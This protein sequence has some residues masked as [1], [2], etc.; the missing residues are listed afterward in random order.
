MARWTLPMSWDKMPATPCRSKLLPGT[1]RSEE[2]T[3]YGCSRLRCR[4]KLISSES[5]TGPNFSR[6]LSRAAS[7]GAD[8]RVWHRILQVFQHQQ[9]YP[10]TRGEDSGTHLGLAGGR[11]PTGAEGDCAHPAGQ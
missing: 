4:A 9:Y 1:K 5:G 11:S 6:G 7:A 8:P 3:L 2:A 10:A